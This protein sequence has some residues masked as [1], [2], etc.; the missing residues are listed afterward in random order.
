MLHVSNTETM[1]N[2]AIEIARPLVRN[3]WHPNAVGAEIVGY[4]QDLCLETIEDRYFDRTLMLMAQDVGSWWR[5]D[6]AEIG[7]HIIAIVD[8][9]DSYESKQAS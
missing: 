5:I 6:D 2:E 4:F 1:L 7:E 8:E 9:Y 3:K